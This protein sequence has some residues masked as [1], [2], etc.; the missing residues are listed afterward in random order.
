MQVEADFKSRVFFGGLVAKNPTRKNRFC[1][2][3]DSVMTEL[4]VFWELP[5][6]VVR[7]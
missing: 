3:G 5:R 4:V 1:Q 2:S 7:I 6:C